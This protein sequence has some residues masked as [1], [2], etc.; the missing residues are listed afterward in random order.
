MNVHVSY[1]LQKSPVLEKDFQHQVEKLRKRLH[2]FRPELVHLKATVEENSPREGVHVSL[3]LRLPSGQMAVQTSAPSAVTAVKNA[4]DDLLHQ[5][6]RHKDLLRTAKWRRRRNQISERREPQVPFEETLASVHPPTVSG[7]DVRSYVNINLARLERFV[8][9]EI[10]M[11]EAQEMIPADSVSKDEVIDETIAAALGDGDGEEKPERLSLEP[12]LYRLALHALD[13]LSRSDESD[14]HAVPLED[15]MRP[16]NV[17]ASDEAEL[18]FHQPDESITGATVIRDDRI[19]T[20]EQIM[21]SDETLLVIAST[22]RSIQPRAREAFILYAIEGFAVDEISAI[23]GLKAE[24]V[25]AS[26]ATARDHL[27]KAP[28]LV[29]ASSAK[30][31]PS[32]AA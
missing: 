13:D 5:L 11:R 4:F 1:R 29:R 2:V 18:Q 7:E 21:A 32:G 26:I 3:N 14:G 12:W 31:I 30:I 10:Y 28:G 27:R 20:P 22:L 6:T 16:R 9:R 24:G 8:E 15:S 23:T 25:V 19:A 17:R